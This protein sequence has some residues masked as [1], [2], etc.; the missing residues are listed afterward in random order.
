MEPHER[1]IVALDVPTLEQAKQHVCTLAPHVGIFK[2][3]LELCEAVGTPQVV[4]FIH[5]LGGLVFRD[6]KYKDIPNTVAGAARSV[7]QPGV[8]MINLHCDGGSNMMREASTAIVEVSEARRLPR[9]LLLG[10]TVLTSL[11]Y[12]DFVE[13][14]IL[15]HNTEAEEMMDGIDGACTL[16][17]YHENCAQ[18]FVLRWASLAQQCGLDGIVCSPWE[19][20]NVRDACGPRFV[21]VNPSIRPNWAKDPHDQKR[22]ATP[23]DAIRAGADYLV[24]GRPILKPPPEIGSPVDAAKR[25]ADEIAAAAP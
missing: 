7:V 24:I 3:G 19:T 2:V 15:E 21:I 23:A 1:I 9:P 13:L 11:S 4:Q 20:E 25:I 5:G 8:R 10:V 14:G 16:E 6:G 17:E 22:C 18:F 12:E